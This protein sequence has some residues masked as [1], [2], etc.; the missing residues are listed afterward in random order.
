MPYQ[1]YY[2]LSNLLHPPSLFDQSH[3]DDGGPALRRARHRCLMSA[4]F[5]H[6]A[7]QGL[8]HLIRRPYQIYYALSNLLCPT[9]PYQIC[10]NHLL[11]LTSLTFGDGE[12]AL[13]RAHHRCLMS[14]PFP[15]RAISFNWEAVS[16]LL[17]PT[18]GVPNAIAATYLLPSHARPSEGCSI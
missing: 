6:T 10:S 16:N 11:S 3:F 13:R 1:F 9:M 18:E 4:P 15:R 12:P 5:P 8:F 14:A 17:C 7:F 2:A